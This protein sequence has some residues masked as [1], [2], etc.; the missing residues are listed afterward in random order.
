MILK[1]SQNISLLK[2]LYIGKNSI[3]D[4]AANDIA[5]IISCNTQL[6]EVDISGNNLTAFG[7]IKIAKAL[8]SIFT[9]TKL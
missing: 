9:L 8:Q 1:A 4:K 2:K 3:S 5:A 7:A 6:Q